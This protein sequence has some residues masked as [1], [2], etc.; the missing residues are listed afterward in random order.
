MNSLRSRS[1]VSWSIYEHDFLANF[2]RVNPGQVIDLI[3]DGMD[4]GTL[5]VGIGARRIGDAVRSEIG[6]Q[7]IEKFL[8]S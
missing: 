6:Q 8:A 3:E 7:S 2:R 1:N 5:A 4:E